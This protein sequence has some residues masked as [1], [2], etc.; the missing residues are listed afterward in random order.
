MQRLTIEHQISGVYGPILELITCHEAF[1][2]AVE[3]VAG[4][5]LFH[6]VVDSDTTASRLIELM[7]REQQGRVTFIPL[8]RILQQQ[9]RNNG[10]MDDGVDADDLVLPSETDARP[11]LSHIE[12]APVFRPAFK[13]VYRIIDSCS[14]YIIFPNRFSEKRFFVAI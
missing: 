7:A 13:Q 8:N 5:S 4:N 11:L 6:V 2:T 10:G 3:A 1:S 12:F 14:N 9:Q